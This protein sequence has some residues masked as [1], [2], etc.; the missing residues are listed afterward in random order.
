MRLD[1]RRRRRKLVAQPRVVHR[2]RLGCHKANI[3][4][5]VRECHLVEVL[6]DRA[7]ALLVDRLEFH[8]DARPVRA[9]P[10]DRAVVEYDGRVLLGVDLEFVAVRRRA[11]A[12]ARRDLDRSAGGE[13][14]VHPRRGDADALL[15]ARLAQLVELRPVE[16]LAED[17]RNLRL[18]DAGAG[19]FDHEPVA[20]LFDLVDLD[21]DVGQ[22]PRFF[23]R[24]ERVVDRFLDRGQHGARR[25][26]EAEQVPVL[27]EEFADG[28]F[29]LLLAD[30]L[31]GRI[32]GR[33]PASRTLRGRV[34]DGLDIGFA[35]RRVRRLRVGR[36]DRGI[37]E[38]RQR[39]GFFDRFARLLRAR[40]GDGLARR[41]PRGRGLLRR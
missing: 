22:D 11:R 40:R 19:V 20:V 30:G 39:F 7:F 10:L 26:V 2:V 4:V 15:S 24:V 21:H 36:L 1:R 13:L 34:R 27:G 29:A 9:F 28:N 41:A 35:L 14:R 38:Q 18:D 5:R 17:L 37:A 31:G 23:A 3:R 33:R 8:L 6:I 16:Q 25:A 12:G 32:L